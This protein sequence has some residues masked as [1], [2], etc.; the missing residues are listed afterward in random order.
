M[1]EN[2][3]ILHSL[4]LQHLSIS[5]E[6]FLFD[7]IHVSLQYFSRIHVI[8]VHL[9]RLQAFRSAFLGF[10]GVIL[11]GVFPDLV[12]VT[13]PLLEYGILFSLFDQTLVSDVICLSLLSF[14]NSFVSI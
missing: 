12:I 7:H 11:N 14:S 10:P 2:N 6:I 3:R 5:F 1:L 9:V 13:L 8:H 4:V